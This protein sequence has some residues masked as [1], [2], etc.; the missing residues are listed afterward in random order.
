VQAILYISYDSITD[1]ISKSQTIPLLNQYSKRN[2][3]Y[4]ISF[5]KK[6]NEAK[7]NKNYL[8]KKIRWHCIKFETNLILKL[9]SL[10]SCQIKILKILLLDKIDIIQTRSYV[11]T[12]FILIP[13][14]LKKFRLIFDIRGFWFDEKFEAEH[15]SS[16][17]YNVLKILEK[18]LF[19]F[20]DKIITLSHI[21]KKI[22]FKNFKIDKKKIH[23]IPTFTN[24]KKFKNN[25]KITPIDKIIFG[26]VGNVG[27]NYEFNKV[28][29]FFEYFDKINNNWELIIANNQ[30]S[31]IPLIETLPFKKKIKLKKVKFSQ[32]N[33]FYSKIDLCVYF[34]NKKFSK[35][36]S[37][38]TKL[39]ELIATN[40]PF[41]TNSKIGD[42][43]QIILKIKMKEFL[44]NKIN[45]S[46]LIKIN[47][48]I[49]KIKNKELKY[50]SR[51][52]LEHF[53]SEN[54]NLMK[55]TSIVK[56]LKK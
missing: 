8:N 52:K 7:K 40:T 27:M 42:I 19:I 41:I 54:L 10:I 24:F 38:P 12:I 11:P 33:K 3:V 26:Y 30:I 4:L 37:C 2:K 53:F 1:D 28:I 48:I 16:L 50:N 18:F 45:T 35:K 13:K 44:I 23:V 46:K 6:P 39:G 31:K 55:Y 25:L 5:E 32:M 9:F 14:L 49:L 20:A 47:R 22:I 17:S 29:K 15:I 36:A 51:L 43:N 56:S 34:L 21:S